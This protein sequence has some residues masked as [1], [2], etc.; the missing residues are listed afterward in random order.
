V[1]VLVQDNQV[2]FL[3]IS[4]NT[5]PIEPYFYEQGISNNKHGSYFKT[6][7]EFLISKAEPVRPLSLLNSNK[8]QYGP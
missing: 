7:K 8:K 4:D 6:F 3:A 1:E 5:P 2:K